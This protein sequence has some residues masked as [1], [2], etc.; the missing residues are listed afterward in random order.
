MS[1]Q[2]FE[3]PT[4]DQI[5]T[6]LQDQ[7]ERISEDQFKPDVILGISR[8]GLVPARIHSDLLENPNLATVRTECYVGGAEKSVP[9]L[10]Q[11]LS[12]CVDG[13]TVLVVD[14]IADT[15]RSLQLVKEYVLRKGA[16]QVRV[17]TLYGKPWSVLKPD[18]CEKETELWVVFPWDLRETVRKEF[19]NR[20][21]LSVSGLSL[22]LVDSG[23]PKLHVDQFLKKMTGESPAETHQ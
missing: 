7:A 12:M 5:Y 10:S 16:K 9:V 3:V 21:T 20:R 11:E 23:L 17:A 19:A 13:R 4:W 1:T 2:R 6:M 22:R 14:D 15:G 18:Y 8:G